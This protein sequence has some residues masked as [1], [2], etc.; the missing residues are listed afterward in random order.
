MYMSKL[1]PPPS[2]YSTEWLKLEGT[3]GGG[4]HAK[5]GDK[6]SNSLLKQGHLEQIAQDHVQTI[7]VSIFEAGDST[8][9]LGNLC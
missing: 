6:W 5:E 2:T 8:A 9:S 1:R 4:R 3:S 7:S